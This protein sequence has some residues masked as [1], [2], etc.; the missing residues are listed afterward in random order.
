MRSGGTNGPGAFRTLLLYELRM[1]VRDTRTMLIAVVAPVVLFPVFLFVLHLVEEAEERRLDETTYRYAVAGDRADWAD[2]LVQAAVGL[3]LPGDTAGVPVLERAPLPAEALPAEREALDS[4]FQEEGLHLLVRGYSV[5]RWREVRGREREEEA[6]REAQE[7]GRGRE[8][9]AGEGAA[10]EGEAPDRELP[11]VRLEYRASSDFGRRAERLVQERLQRLRS[12]Q[13]EEAFVARGLPVA[14]DSVVPLE[15]E[16]IATSQK[17]AGAFLGQILTPFLLFLMLSGGSIVAVDAI[18]G[19]KERGTLETLLTTAA[20]RAQIVDAK[21]AAVVVVGLAVTVVNVLNL[22]LYLVL[23]L[24]ELPTSL[25]VDLSVL[26]VV[27]LF[28]LLAPLTLLVGSALLLLSGYA[29]SYKEYQIYFLPLFL[30]FLAPSLAV[31]LPGMD[32]R[33]AVAFVPVSGV[34]VGVREIM[35]GE[36]DWPFLLIAFLSTAAAAWGLARLTERTL[37]TERLISGVDRDEA[38]LVGGAQLFPRHVLRWFG[39][40]W[41]VFFL[42]SLWAGTDLGLRGQIVVNLVGLFL[43]GSLLMIRSY[44]LPVREALAL[45]PVRPAVWLAVVVGAP[46]TFV[47]GIGLANLV[48]MWVFPVPDRMI[49]AFGEYLGGQELPLWQMLVFL[50]VLPGILE[51]IAFRGVLV[52]GLRK[53]LRPVALCL[54]VGLIFGLFHVSLF[55]IVPTAYL[56]A[57]LTAVVLLTGSIFPAML[58]HALNNAAALVPSHLGWVG[59]DTAFPVWFYGLAVAG[60]AAAFALLWV[61][62]TPYPGLRR[63]RGDGSPARAEAA[64]GRA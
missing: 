27:L 62:R 43:G 63:V 1:L 24:F 53:A 33:S 61:G 35:V 19:E 50:T 14:P 37:S 54:V 38:D 40:L 2:S 51:E 4:L 26:D 31:V 20:S 39:G 42:V 36:R 5:Q 49:E 25:A 29:K 8:E 44:R 28:A 30:A 12:H 55:R 11:V 23:G 60:A 47:L 56:G 64:A 59:A 41:V 52:Y 58:W 13:R 6:A 7:D 3:R 17:E 57:I 32:L 9:P 22:L 48:D 15:A 45:R 16:N 18:S 46:S 10:A 21:L 34:G